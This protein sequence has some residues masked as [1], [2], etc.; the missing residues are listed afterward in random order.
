MEH[1]NRWF[2]KTKEQDK[3]TFQKKKGVRSQHLT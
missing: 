1:K 2:F 3:G